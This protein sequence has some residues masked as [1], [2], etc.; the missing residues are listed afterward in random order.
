[1]LPPPDQAVRNAAHIA[2]RLGDKMR[3]IHGAYMARYFEQLA[4]E[5]EARADRLHA[6][7]TARTR[8]HAAGL[9]VR[10]LHDL[11]RWITDLRARVDAGALADLAPVELGHGTANLRCETMVKTMLADLEHLK[12]LPES[13]ADRQARLMI[14]LG[15]FGRMRLAIG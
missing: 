8:D 1:V 12:M 9:R 5:A 15:N 10:D 13:G 11:V 3:R 6:L 4:D 14:L 2:R 7:L